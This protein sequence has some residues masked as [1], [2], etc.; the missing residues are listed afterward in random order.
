VVKTSTRDT[1]QG[2]FAT[3]IDWLIIVLL[4]VHG[5][6][7][8]VPGPARRPMVVRPAFSPTHAASG[9]ATAARPAAARQADPD[10]ALLW[11]RQGEPYRQTIGIRV[12]AG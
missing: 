8:D 3:V 12:L 2:A 1:S 5:H 9:R 11:L 6:N 4:V 10:A 7:G